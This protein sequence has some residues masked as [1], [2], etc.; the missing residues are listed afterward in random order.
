M[1]TALPLLALAGMLTACGSSSS[2]GTSGAPAGGSSSSSTGGG[3]SGSLTVANG[4]FTES[5]ILAQMYADLLQKAGFSVTVKTVGSQEVFQPALEKGQIAVVPEYAATYAD[6]LETEVT[7]TSTPTA[8]KPSL[9]ATIANLKKYE[10][11]KGLDNLE[12]S[13]AVDQNAFAV[14][15]KFAGQHSL[16]TLSDLGKSGLSVK[17]G[18]PAEC[19]KRPYCLD[20]L[21]NGYGIKVSG[22][23][24]YEFDSLPAKQALKNN[25]VQIA[26]V[27]TTDATLGQ[28]GLTV[29]TDD[30]HLQNADYL[31]PIVNAAQLKAH[32][33][34]ATAINPLASQLTTAELGQLDN[35][36]DGERMTVQDVAKK[37]LQSKSLL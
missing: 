18:A 35:Q 30:K 9:S 26:E 24:T 20:A 19:P 15:Q 34:I 33:Q 5:N 23:S 1:L 13:Q 4:G 25:K 2:G 14:T 22:V 17:L 6:S 36:V 12:P 16:A 21:K 37:F 11:K 3:A 31:V 7:G 29:L 32:P 28:L 10:A 27:S 8:G